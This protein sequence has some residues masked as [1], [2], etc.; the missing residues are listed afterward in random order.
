MREYGVVD[1]T[2]EKKII[3]SGS[4]STCFILCMRDRETTKT[5]VAHIDAMTLFP[6]DIFRNHFRHEV[7][8]VYIHQ[9]I[10]YTILLFC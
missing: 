8:D 1:S 5:M 3:G 9:Y 2:T 6:L 10:N 4:A 7:T